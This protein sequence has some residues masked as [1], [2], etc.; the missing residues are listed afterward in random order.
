MRLFKNKLYTEHAGPHDTRMKRKE[1]TKQRERRRSALQERA[2]HK[3][4]AEADAISRSIPL[5]R[6][7][8]MASSAK[9]RERLLALAVVRKQIEAGAK[10]SEFLDFARG[11]VRDRDNNCRW[12]A[13]IVIGESIKSDPNA[14][15]DVVAEFGNSP[16]D[17]MRAAIG[18]VLLEHLL[19][20]YFEWFFPLAQDQVRRG[21]HRFLDTIR[22]CWF[23][24]RGANYEHAQR[25]IE[26]ARR[27]M[28]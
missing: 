7:K 11:L 27:G 18:C 9:A 2:L 23:N 17:D 12:Q 16:D 6:L 3:A 24:N 20:K 10:P 15:W 5:D 8:Q 14:V 26:E 28:P 13:V 19:D 22:M 21:R 1:I 25:W 4:W